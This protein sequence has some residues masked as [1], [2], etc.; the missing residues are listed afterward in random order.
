MHKVSSLLAGHY[1]EKF[2]THGA[3]SLGVDW[4]NDPNLTILRQENM[5]GVIK[6]RSNRN[7]LLDV[8][9]GYGHLAELILKNQLNIDYSGIDLVPNMIEYAKKEYSNFNFFQDVFLSFN[10]NIYDYIICNGILTQKL[11]ASILEMDE[12]AKRLIIKMYE[13]SGK[14]VAFNM[15][16]THVNFQRNNL[17]YKNPV[18]LLGWCFSELTPHVIYNSSYRL[19]YEY[20]VYLYK[21]DFIRS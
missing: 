18:E 13:L 8:G 1:A 21:P 20:T 12:Y 10:S 9:C 19:W 3:T 4:G 15:M 14:G 17:Y 7:S 6:D 11:T 16:N 5:L 2:A